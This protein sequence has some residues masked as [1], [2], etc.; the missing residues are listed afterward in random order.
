MLRSILRWL[1]FNL[2]GAIG[3]GVQLAALWAL[4]AAGM[5]YL[6]A[7]ALAVEAAVLHNFIW[8]E[9]FTWADRDE[10]GG[11]LARLLRFNLTAGTV[12][13]AGN[14]LFMSLLVGKAHFRSMIANLIS[15]AACSI[16]NFLV[17]DRWVF[18]SALR[19]EQHE[20]VQ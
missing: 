8:H 16:V 2:V 11:T 18:R 15:I 20:L 19:P 17:S 3:I 13:I 5:D 4:T 12:S 1:K 14:L 7:T 9:R 6:F 10:R